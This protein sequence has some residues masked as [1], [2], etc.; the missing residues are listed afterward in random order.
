MSPAL[1]ANTNMKLKCFRMSDAFEDKFSGFLET[2]PK[3]GASLNDHYCPS[4]NAAKSRGVPI[5]RRHHEG[6]WVLSTV[7]VLGLLNWAWQARCG[8]NSLNAK[9]TLAAFIKLLFPGLTFADFKLREVLERH[10]SCTE[11]IQRGVCKHVAAFIQGLQRYD[12]DFSKILCSFAVLWSMADQCTTLR[13][14]LEEVYTCIADIINNDI[15]THG[16]SKDAISDEPQRRGKVR[17]RTIQPELKLALQA[18]AAK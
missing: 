18:K 14:S 16:F 9:A 13:S 5:T 15:A 7:G 3:L 11:E 4:S 1:S 8:E 2:F 17:L 12:T 10:T 6:S